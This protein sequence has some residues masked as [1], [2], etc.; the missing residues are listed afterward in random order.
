MDDDVAL[1]T[2]LVDTR[3][4]SRHEVYGGVLAGGGYY[5]IRNVATGAESRLQPGL[6][7]GMFIVEG[8]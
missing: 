7:G 2:I 1:C 6:V 5:L 8:S 4:G 3:D